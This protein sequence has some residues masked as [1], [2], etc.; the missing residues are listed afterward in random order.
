[1][2]KRYLITSP[3][4]DLEED[5]PIGTIIETNIN[6]KLLKIAKKDSDSIGHFYAPKDVIH[7][8]E[9]FYQDLK[10]IKEIPELK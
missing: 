10:A 4:A 2:R 7:D 5:L 8:V 6:Q 3:L 1:M 9:V